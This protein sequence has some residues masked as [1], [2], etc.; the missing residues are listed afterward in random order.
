M[1]RQNCIQ[2]IS[3]W[4]IFSLKSAT[5]KGL[6]ANVV[7]ECVCSCDE[8]MSYISKTK[9]HLAVRVKEHLTGN[10]AVH[11]LIS[12]CQLGRHGT[13]DNFKVL[14][15]GCH[16]LDIKIKE[17]LYIKSNKPKLNNQIF[18]KGSSF[19]LNVF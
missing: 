15:C 10:S 9:W 11:D 14:D 1:S 5:P 7:H 4:T 17:A 19:L 12:Q 3:Y 13:I 16:D 8:S 2:N 18:Q 6:K